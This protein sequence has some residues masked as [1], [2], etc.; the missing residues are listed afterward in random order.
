[1]SRTPAPPRGDSLR[2]GSPTAERTSEAKQGAHGRQR[3]MDRDAHTGSGGAEASAAAAF[4]AAVLDMDG[5]VTRTATLHA[6]AW[7]ELFDEFL[8]VRAEREG[9]RFVAFDAHADYLTYVDGRPRE[10]GVRSFL[11]SRGIVVPEGGAADVPGAE[12]VH[13]LAERKDAAFEEQLR[14]RG[15]D[16][17]EST[18]ALIGA[19]RASGVKVGVVTS[20]RRGREILHEARI[21][22][23]FDACVDGNDLGRRGLRGKPEP[24]SFVA[25][26]ADLGVT[27]AR[28]I[29]VEDATS[30][31]A[32]AKAGGFG[33]V[34][35]VDRGGNRLA[36]EQHGADVVVEDLEELDVAALN[37]RF[38][39]AR[40]PVSW[41]IEQEGFDAARERG[42]E[43]LFTIGNG[44]LGV[45]G[46][47]DTPVPVAQ[48]DLFVAGVYDRKQAS[49]PYSE[50][51]FMDAGRD[52]A[53]SEIVS[54]P[55]PFR[56][57]ARLDGQRMSLAETQWR[58]HRRTLDMRAGV[59]RSSAR[60]EP[61][62]GLYVSVASR[63][64]ASLENVHLLL[65][66]VTVCLE[67]FSGMLELD[68][69]IDERDLALN[70]PHLVP[71]TARVAA[72]G[73][74]VR[75]FTTRAS[76]IE[77][78]VAQRTVL[79]DAA[80]REARWRVE[81]ALGEALTFRRCVAVYT[82]RDVEDPEAAAVEALGNSISGFDERFAAHE[83]CW[84]QIWH[85]A[86]VQVGGRAA[87]EQALRF[88]AYHLSSAADHDPR[89]SVGGRALTGRAYEGHV[90]WDVEVF[91]LPFFLHTR[92]DVARC[93]LAYRHA[94]LDGARRRARGLGYAGACYAW[95]STVT[96]EDVTPRVIVL[97][98]T[99]KE[100]PIFT[101][102][103][104]IHVTADV[105]FGVWRYWEATRDADFLSGQGAEILAETA[106]F[107]AS[108]CALDAD[109]YH[110]RGVVG[111]DEYH[112]GVDDNAYTNWMARFNLERAVWVCEWL[113]SERPGA[114]STLEERIALEDAEVEA[115]ADVAR[116][117]YVPVP[118]E[119][120]VIEQFAGFFD[121]EEYS[122]TS[123]ERFRAPV[124]RLFDWEKINRLQLLKQADVLMLPFLFPERFDRKTLAANYDYY[125]ARTDHGSSL[126]PGVHAAL[127][128]RLGL[129]EQAE[130]YWQQSLML[131]LS[132]VMGNSTLGV[133]PACMGATWQA[134]VYHFLGVRFEEGRAVTDEAAAER[135]P[136]DWRS[137]ALN[138]R[139][140]GRS[141]RVEVKR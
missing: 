50:H 67:N 16:L 90:F 19:L 9:T 31:V 128:A 22:H 68:A 89:V 64:C 83:A 127:A 87:A 141:H 98:T 51:E 103:Q 120:G 23:L 26:A 39:A 17:F 93:L 138:L 40:E 75:C 121:L 100:I 110:I 63:R 57:E 115:W 76:G 137:V 81:A 62:P 77:T 107:W 44:Y 38:A 37:D 43:S 58:M 34:V 12:T 49:R 53:F 80:S 28:A 101:G 124:D 116:R 42:V 71:R 105:A 2:H 59:L 130:R 134:L 11:D 84:G 56:V 96:G 131:D 88:H 30:G 1:M 54:F 114:W 99:R 3:P 45:R 47:L 123:D 73:T 140:R 48:G 111:P 92:P 113:R 25:C 122:L 32:A 117:L 66:E 65:Q 69:S 14:K 8:R 4:D 36:L 85:A 33:L 136:A 108:R 125:E 41:R 7:K 132:N 118:N 6:A 104:Q 18:I 102:T 94:T 106:R 139:W 72:F 35:G 112:H 109:S 129:R 46:A 55:F 74:D 61:R 133:H 21:E 5:I 119:N 135:L 29:V 15:V 27:P 86:D 24:D 10:A 70:H 52:G 97:R 20:S 95:E 91:L 126:S 13:G 60:Y 78:C 82:S 79:A